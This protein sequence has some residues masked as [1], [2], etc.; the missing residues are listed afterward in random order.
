MV[1]PSASEAVDPLTTGARSSTD[2]GTSHSWFTPART[3]GEGSI[4]HGPLSGG[5]SARSAPLQRAH[6]HQSGKDRQPVGDDP[7]GEDPGDRGAGRNP[8]L[9]QPGDE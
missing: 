7:V 9:R 6:A 4:F 5:T 8:T 3:P 2:S 1:W